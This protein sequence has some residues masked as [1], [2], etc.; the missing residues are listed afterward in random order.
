MG[1]HGM[2]R[3]SCGRFVSSRFGPVG[4]FKHGE[5]G[6]EEGWICRRCLPNWTPRDGRGRGPEAGYCGV[7]QQHQLAIWKAGGYSAGHAALREREG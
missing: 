6:E 7:L 2:P 4:W 1:D 3:C 5:Y